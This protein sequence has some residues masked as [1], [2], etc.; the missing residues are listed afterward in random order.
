[1]EPKCIRIVAE[2][3]HSYEEV[4]S[5]F[6][7]AIREAGERQVVLVDARASLANPSHQEMRATASFGRRIAHAIGPRVA[8]VVSGTLRYGLARMLSTLG[9]LLGELEYEAFH[10]LEQAERWVHGRLASADVEGGG[11]VSAHAPAKR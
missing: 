6:E 7:A 1:L 3:E 9:N 5:A 4:V 8:L 11:A 2:G 10:D